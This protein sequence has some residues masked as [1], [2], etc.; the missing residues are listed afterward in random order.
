M[1]PCE[2]KKL[3]V[4]ACSMKE[5]MDLRG[6]IRDQG[7]GAK[8]KYKKQNVQDLVS[9]NKYNAALMLA[10]MKLREKELVGLLLG[11]KFKL[12]QPVGYK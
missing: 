1:L 3:H 5:E 4:L 7:T 8:T 6:E 12:L 10:Y 9:T 2:K 11:V